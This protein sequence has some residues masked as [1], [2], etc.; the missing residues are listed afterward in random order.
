MYEQYDEPKDLRGYWGGESLP[1]ADLITFLIQP[2]Q[3]Y[4]SHSKAYMPTVA[5][6]VDG[7]RS[8]HDAYYSIK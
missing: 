8:I 7:N 2:L 3:P 4:G 6:G 5:E 1:C